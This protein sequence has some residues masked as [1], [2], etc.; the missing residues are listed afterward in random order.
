MIDFLTI[1]Q[2]LGW[3]AVGI[4]LYI[5]LATAGFDLGGGILVP[6]TGKTDDERRAIINVMAPTWDGNQVWFIAFGGLLF[7]VWPRVYAA[8]FSGLYLAV[9]LILWALFLR[10]VAFE[11][12]SKFLSQKVRYFWD[13]MLALGSFLTI[14]A[15]GIAVGNIFLGFPFAFNPETLR[16][17]YGSQANQFIME[18]A[19]LSLLK[20]FS[21][22]AILMAIFTVVL[23]IMHGACYISLRTTG[24][25]Y[26]RF[27]S[28]VKVTTILF[29]ALFIIISIW[30][31]FLPGYHWNPNATLTHLSDGIY[32]PINGAIVTVTGGGWYANYTM[33]P[34]MVLAPALAILGALGILYYLNKNAT[35]EMFVM[36]MLSVLG[37][38]LTLALSIFP[39]IMPSSLMPNQSLVIW[40]ATSSKASLIGILIVAVVML[41]IIFAYTRFVYRKMWPNNR[42]ITTE[43][44]QAN[45][46]IFY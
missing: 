3:L 32:H 36:S 12:R 43:E 34:W 38:I 21:P 6:F 28:I 22:F 41:P 25:L 2:L 14:F 37:S 1:L 4:A 20:L 19:V 27:K 18:P 45:T 46:H 7:A 35:K 10:P 31:I 11:Y 30:L 13:W 15:L 23:S 39:F 5:F 44:V 16:F 17:Y 42:K 33:H 8:S 26:H 40:N 9:L 24:H 29:L